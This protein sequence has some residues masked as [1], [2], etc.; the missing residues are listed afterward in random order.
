MWNADQ[1][2]FTFHNVSIK[3]N[4]ATSEENAQ[5]YTL[6]S[7][8]SLL[9]PSSGHGWC[10]RKRTLHSTMSLL[11]HNRITPIELQIHFF[12][13]HNVSI[14]SNC[15]I[16]HRLCHFPLHSTMSLLNLFSL[17][18][19][20]LLSVFTFHNVSIK[21]HTPLCFHNVHRTLH[22]TMSLLNHKHRKL[23]R[24]SLTF[25]YIPQCLY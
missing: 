18:H 25:L 9:N 14:K 2:S 13:F 19:A 15:I 23:S 10:K 6:H 12:T 4:A 21:S 5:T 20:L 3:S 7:T 11:N 24:P 17:F 1:T 16:I 22:S 8:M